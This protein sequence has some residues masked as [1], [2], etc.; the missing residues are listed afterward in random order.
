M[1][2][3]WQRTGP[4]GSNRRSTC[5]SCS[6]CGFYASPRGKRKGLGCR[7]KICLNEWAICSIWKVLFTY[8]STYLSYYL[9]LSNFI[10][11]YIYV[12][13]YIVIYIYVSTV[14]CTSTCSYIIC[15]IKSGISP[16]ITSMTSIYD[17]YDVHLLGPYTLAVPVFIGQS[18]SVSKL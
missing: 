14:C 4:S 2:K 1:V 6:A 10:Y 7:H 5:P 17:F 15:S 9:P 12:Y 3:S 16:N 8:L 13:I 11:L 18:G